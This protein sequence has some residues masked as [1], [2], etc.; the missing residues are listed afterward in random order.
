MAFCS[1][2]SIRGGP[3]SAAP[4]APPWP[5]QAMLSRDAVVAR[6]ATGAA[7]STPTAGV[8]AGFVSLTR[9]G[10]GLGPVGARPGSMGLGDAAGPPLVAGDGE[11]AGRR[12]HRPPSPV[13]HGASGRT[14]PPLRGWN[15][16]LR[17]LAL[18]QEGEGE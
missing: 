8:G 16:H 12:P 2:G 10:M 18:T 14:A 15:R 6:R 4:V 13:R 3:P 17:R 9:T 1:S 7:S 11:D 5:V